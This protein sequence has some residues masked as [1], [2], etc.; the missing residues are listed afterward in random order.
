MKLTF[1]IEFSTVEVADEVVVEQLDDAR[2]SC[3][4]GICPQSIFYGE[5]EG[6][7]CSIKSRP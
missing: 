1:D 2:S 3:E 6:S 7:T 4:V 5:R